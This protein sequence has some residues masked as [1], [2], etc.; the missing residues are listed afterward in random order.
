MRP[1]A[2]LMCA[3]VSD[4]WGIRWRR[5]WPLILV[6]PPQ[7]GYACLPRFLAPDSI[8]TERSLNSALSIIPRELLTWSVRKRMVFA[9]KTYLEAHSLAVL[10]LPAKRASDH[11][12]T[13]PSVTRTHTY[14]S[15]CGPLP[16]SAAAGGRAKVTAQLSQDVSLTG[17]HSNTDTGLR[18]DRTAAR[19]TV[20]WAWG[21]RR[22]RACLSAVVYL[23]RCSWAVSVL[24][25][26]YRAAGRYPI[27]SD[28]R[29]QIRP[30]SP[31][32]TIRTRG[33]ASAMGYTLL[34][35]HADRAMMGHTLPNSIL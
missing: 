14:C 10:P 6:S 24:V 12:G 23:S 25:L 21:N 9:H 34:D 11:S 5:R 15:W 3:C 2:Y 7:T 35:T 19:R 20:D 17:M 26:C 30:S 22:D 13:A 32:V 18:G 29:G 28:E 16:R 31:P 27:R 4:A 1:S 33:W 8:S